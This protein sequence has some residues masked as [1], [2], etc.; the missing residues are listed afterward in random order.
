VRPAAVAI[1]LGLLAPGSLAELLPP[2]VAAVEGRDLP[3]LL[4][5]PVANLRAWATENGRQRPVLLQVDER[6]GTDASAPFAYEG[7]A[8]PRPD[9]VAG[10]D[11]NDWVLLDAQAVGDRGRLPGCAE[12]EVGADGRPGWLYLGTG[13]G[14]APSSPLRFDPA[15]DLVRGERYAVGFAP[16]GHAW[17][18]RLVLGE[19]ANLLDRSKA[20]LRLDLRGGLGKIERNEEDVRARTTGIH[21]G[22]LRI[23]R[24]IEVRGRILANVYSRPVRDRFL[25]YRNGFTIPTT[26]QLPAAQVLVRR[27]SLRI[28]MDLRPAAIGAATFAAAPVRVP[29]EVTGAEG[30]VSSTEPLQWYLLQV[31]S[32]GLLGWLDIDPAAGSVTLYYRDD[33]RH[34]DPP[35]N[36]VGEIGHHGF[37]YRTSGRLPT[38][39]VHVTSN[40]WILAGAALRDPDAAKRALQIRTTA[41]VAP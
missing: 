24:E 29:R 25:F 23:V 39:V 31:G 27:A 33:A 16:H 19:S 13:A 40:A 10:L 2:D 4:G 8:E 18:D 7:G 28:T 12:V 35:E 22:P 36:Y 32:V 5:T 1:S 26:V 11:E 38:G 37:L 21:V 20:R 14:E 9:P 41:E 15:G 17:L 30:A 34:P 3:S 6:L